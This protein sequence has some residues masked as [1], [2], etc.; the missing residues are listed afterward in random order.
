MFLG[1]FYQQ[2]GHGRFEPSRL[3]A[4]VP[5]LPP[6]LQACARE[7]LTRCFREIGFKP[8]EFNT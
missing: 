3:K 1:S 8:R 2:L 4:A 7:G 6:M 5:T